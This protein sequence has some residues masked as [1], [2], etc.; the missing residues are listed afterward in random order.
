MLLKHTQQL[1]LIPAPST[2]KKIRCWSTQLNFNILMVA[3]PKV[4]QQLRLL[5]KTD[6]D[7]TQL[8]NLWVQNNQWHTGARLQTPHTPLH[9]SARQWS[10]LCCSVLGWTLPCWAV[11]SAQCCCSCLLFPSALGHG[12]E[13]VPRWL[14]D[15]ACLCVTVL[16]CTAATRADLAV[17]LLSAS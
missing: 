7:S 2:W 15:T 3:H 16:G 17:G 9:S 13:A 6:R 5:R 14:C 11:S 4:K 12:Q 8:M 10:R 1:H